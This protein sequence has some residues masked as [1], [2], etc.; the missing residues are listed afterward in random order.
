[1]ALPRLGLLVKRLAFFLSF[2]VL[3]VLATGCGAGGPAGAAAATVDGTSISRESL[4]EDLDAILASVPAEQRAA[5]FGATPGNYDTSLAANVLSLRIVDVLVRQELDRRGIEITPEERELGEQDFQQNFGPGAADVPANVRER[6]VELFAAQ[7]ALVAAL[8]D[9]EPGAGEISEEELRA[10]YDET[11]DDFMERVGEVACVSH[12]LVAFDE[13]G[14][15][16]VT[17]TPEQEQAALEEA[18]EIRERIDAGEDFEELATTESDDPGSAAAGGDLGCQAREGGYV[19]EFEDAIFEQPVG[20]V[21][22]PVRTEFGYHIIEV[23]SR[24]VVPFEEVR[25]Q[26][27]QSLEQQRGE[28]GSPLTAWLVRQVEASD[29]EVNPQFGTFSAE[30]A[31]QGQ[32]VVPPEG[33]E[34]P[35]SPDGAEPGEELLEPLPQELPR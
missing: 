7:N 16:A 33:P 11:I 25:E 2:V 9:E 13:E 8:A 19:A 21:G 10:Y 4:F 27:R 5:V 29:I 12:I 26:I 6:F 3:A 23:R 24:G 31:S 15:T 17:P 30:G 20:E 22:Q 35:P 28:Q 14:R 32:L 34:P 1:M 18:T